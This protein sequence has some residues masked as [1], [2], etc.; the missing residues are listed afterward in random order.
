[1][2]SALRLHLHEKGNIIEENNSIGKL[3]SL[4]LLRISIG[5]I[6]EKRTL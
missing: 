1:M 6:A 4:S 3:L 5:E 2:V